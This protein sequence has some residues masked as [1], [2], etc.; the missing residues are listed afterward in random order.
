MNIAEEVL[1]EVRRDPSL[2]GKVS[3]VLFGLG[4]GLI[5]RIC[6][7]W[8]RTPIWVWPIGLGI[9]AYLLAPR[10]QAMFQTMLRLFRT[11]SQLRRA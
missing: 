8:K 4:K 10:T 2:F 1:V 3:K 6:A 9:G 11:V 5:N 7:V